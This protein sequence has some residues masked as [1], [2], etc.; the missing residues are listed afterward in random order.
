MTLSHFYKA[1]LTPSQKR[2]AEE[3]AE[4]LFTDV[5]PHVHA[6]ELATIDAE[7]SQ[8]GLELVMSVRMSE[9]RRERGF[10]IHD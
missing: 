4:A 1:H 5:A 9:L 3:D 8:D 10:F 2:R 6:K 7:V